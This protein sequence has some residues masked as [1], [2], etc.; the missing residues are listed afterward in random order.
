MGIDVRIVGPSGRAV[1]VTQIG[2]LSTSPGFFNE[3]SFNELGTI[4]TAFNFYVPRSGKQF[5]ITSVFAYGDKQVSGSANATVEVYEGT[6]ESTITVDKILLQFEIGQNEFHPYNGL[7]LLVNSNRFINAKT[8][9]DD[10]HM[11]ILGFYI[12]KLI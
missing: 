4:D 7:N 12:D 3:T 9:D 8:S 10:V 5:V 6:S 2:S 1:N 11:N